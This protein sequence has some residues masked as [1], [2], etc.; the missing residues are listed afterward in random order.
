MAACPLPACRACHQLHV[1]PQHRRPRRVLCWQ[2]PNSVRSLS[3]K[4]H[5]A[6][7]YC[8]L[9]LP[10]LDSPPCMMFCCHGA[11]EGEGQSQLVLLVVV[12]VATEH[13]VPVP[14]CLLSSA[15]CRKAATRLLH[16]TV[17]AAVPNSRPCAPHTFLCRYCRPADM[18]SSKRSMSSCGPQIM[19]ISGCFKF[20]NGIVQMVGRLPLLPPL[21]QP[22]ALS[23]PLQRLLQPLPHPA[24]A[25]ATATHH[26]Q[27]PC[28]MQHFVMQHVE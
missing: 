22:L 13:E 3:W 21:L 19:K 6:T 16:A 20:N 25:V 7:G 15:C 26:I 18:S 10:V 2:H 5:R 27:V 11:Q 28:H 4:G 8:V 23:T 17:S 1:T 9:E 24:T 12:V 14:A